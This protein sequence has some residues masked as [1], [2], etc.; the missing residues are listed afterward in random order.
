MAQLE[1]VMS[2]AERSL[3]P[4]AVPKVRLE[5]PTVE[6][7][8]LDCQDGDYTIFVADETYCLPAI[9]LTC[10]KIADGLAKKIDQNPNVSAEAH[11]TRISIT[12]ERYVRLPIPDGQLQF[13]ESLNAGT[14]RT[15]RD[16]TIAGAQLL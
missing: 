11:G 12:E 8:V 3:G 7:E 14:W 10:D 6:V 5:Q 1:T 15:G 4:E 16:R 13:D 2:E 9:S